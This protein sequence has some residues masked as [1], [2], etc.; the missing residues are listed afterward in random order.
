MGKLLATLGG[1]FLA[2]MIG[3][4]DQSSPTCG[5]GKCAFIEWGVCPEDCSICNDGLCSDDETA[6][7]CPNDCDICGDGECTDHEFSYGCVKD[8]FRC[9]NLIWGTTV[10]C[11]PESCGMEE[12]LI[13]AH[14]GDGECEPFEDRDGCPDCVEPSCGDGKC[15]LYE[16]GTCE[17]CADDVCGDDFCGHWEGEF[18]L[19]PDDCDVCGDGTCGPSEYGFCNV[20]CRPNLT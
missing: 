1:L 7:S 14:C 10:T 20:D 15:L 4:D 8:C 9:I 5:D 11:L 18:G 19:C 13:C 12:D 2:I 16:W 3:C 6:A 17:D